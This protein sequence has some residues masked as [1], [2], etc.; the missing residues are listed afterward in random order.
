MQEEF[1]SEKGNGATRERGIGEACGKAFGIF[2]GFLHSLQCME[3]KGMMDATLY[4]LKVDGEET[5]RSFLNTR[6]QEKEIMEDEKKG[7]L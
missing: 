6:I 3:C 7:L 1:T 2:K 4:I 5:A